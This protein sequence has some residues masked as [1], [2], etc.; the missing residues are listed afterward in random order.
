ME[1]LECT[2]EEFE[3]YKE[4]FLTLKTWQPTFEYESEIILNK[5]EIDGEVVALIE[6]SKAMYG[7]DNIQ[8]DRDRGTGPLTHNP[9]LF[10]K[11][12]TESS[13]K[14]RLY[15]IILE[16]RI[17]NSPNSFRGVSAISI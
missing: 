7:D 5:I 12:K 13:R 2:K 1:F 4:K 10:S 9:L 16:Y 8:I 6:Y 11:K 17:N 3:T 14:I 15:Y